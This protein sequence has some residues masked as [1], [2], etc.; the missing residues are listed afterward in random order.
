MELARYFCS[1]LFEP[2]DF[3]HYALSVP[4]YTHFT[5]PIRRYPDVMVHRL[6]AAALKLRDRPSKNITELALICERCNDAKTTGR[7]VSERSRDMFLAVFIKECG[8]YTSDAIVS[9]VMDHS[10][11]VLV[12]D[13]GVIKR[14]YTNKLGLQN[15]QFI[16]KKG[17]PHLKL[18]WRA[19]D[20]AAATEQTISVL[21]QLR[22]TLTAGGPLQYNATIQHP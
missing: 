1:G 22:V 17:V 2:D 8:P 18:S 15:V 19:C 9:A 3:R 16:K 12:R 10:F 4:L 13:F 11:D 14:V 5:S 21:T 20:D 7:S 6:L